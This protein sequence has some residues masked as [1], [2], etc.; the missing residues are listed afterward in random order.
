ML[1]K[2]RRMSA[3]IAEVVGGNVEE[4]IPH[5]AMPRKDPDDMPLPTDPRT[6][7][8]GGLFLLA[9]LAALYVASPIVLP[10]VLAIV[11][12]LLLQPLVRLTDRASVPRAIGALLAIVLLVTALAA[13]ISGV[14][15]PAAAWASR[16]PEAIPKTREQL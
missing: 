11:L 15:G 6:I 9:L 2:E 12:K 10:V 1:G 16:L 3:R 7:F 14:A 4:V 13:L 5:S 8:L